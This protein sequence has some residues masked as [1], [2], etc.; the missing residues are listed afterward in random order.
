MAL[1]LEH[2]LQQG[3]NPD[4]V[5]DYEDDRHDPSGWNLTLG[6]HA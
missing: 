1:I 2:I 4:F 5:I 3:R 6:A